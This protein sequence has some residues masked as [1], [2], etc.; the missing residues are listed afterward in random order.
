[1]VFLIRI[2]VVIKLALTSALCSAQDWQDW[3]TPTNEEDLLLQETIERYKEDPINLNTCSAETLH[4]LP[5]LT[6]QDITHVLAHRLKYGAFID[7]LELQVCELS[8]NKIYWL[9]SVASINKQD[10]RSEQNTLHTIILT[11]QRQFPDKSGFNHSKGF[12]GDPN[13]YIIRYRGNLNNK[14]DV[15]YT[16][17]KDVGEAL[18]LSQGTFGLDYNSGYVKMHDVLWFESIVIGDFTGDFGQGVTI[19]SGMRVGKS[20]LVIN[21]VKNNRGIKP[22]RSVSEVGALRGVAT[23]IRRNKT[24]L[25]TWYSRKKLDANVVDDTDLPIF[26]SYLTSGLHRTKSE[27]QDKRAIVSNQFGFNLEHKMGLSSIEFTSI[28]QKVSGQHL[29]SNRV[30]QLFQSNQ[31]F[32]HKH[33]F[34]HR[35]YI[36]NSMF[37]GE[38]TIGSNRSTGFVEGII[39]PLSKSL[40]FT[41]LYRR[42]GKGFIDRYSKTFTESS[43]SRNE[44]GYYIGL[45]FNASYKLTI[46]SYVDRYQFNWLTSSTLTPSRGTDY[47]VDVKYK[48]SK[49][50]QWYVRLKSETKQTHQ[51]LKTSAKQL[52]NATTIK[53]RIHLTTAPTKRLSLKTRYE[54]SIFDNEH[55][56]S[57]GSML[58]QDVR[59]TFPKRRLKL[60]MRLAMANIDQY[61]NRIYAYENDVAYSYSVPFYQDNQTRTYALIQ[62]P[63]KPNIDL[64]CKVGLDYKSD[65]KGFGSGLDSVSSPH[66]TD[67]K[68]QIRIRI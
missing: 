23:T 31:G 52:V 67:V 1:M 19:G 3:S 57:Q 32:F 10:R 25:T 55:Q 66:R 46:S 21:S 33:G 41:A 17:E 35:T 2:I 53:I 60:T 58:Y 38:I 63:I 47:L 28:A 59:I 56:S 29:R 68:F 9:L 50:L 62:Y 37:F 22:Y 43:L 8:R 12:V 4:D 44:T 64:W 49:R 54:A 39:K 27:I 42:L 34:A 18:R 40:S 20:A 51:L 15:G 45:Q 6:D 36:N 13:R 26:T 11:A 24:V 61:A 5:F 7:N 30:Y 14:V 16:G 65:L 48:V